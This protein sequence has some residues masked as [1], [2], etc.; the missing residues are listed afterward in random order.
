[1]IIILILQYKDQ[2]DLVIILK[3][4]IMNIPLFLNDTYLFEC[5]S[6]VAGIGHDEKGFYIVLDQTIF[7]PQGGGQPADQGVLKYGDAEIHILQV[8]QID[9]EIRHYVSASPELRIGT[10]V[11]AK[12]DQ[13]RRMLNARYHTAA[14][15]I[16]NIAEQICPAL[17]AIKGNSFPREAYVEFQG[18]EIPNASLLI[19]SLNKVIHDCL[20]TR[21]FKVNIKEF[22]EQ[23]YKLT[24][25][26][27]NN[28]TFRAMQI[29]DYPPVPCGGTHLSNCSEIGYIE[30]GKIK[31]KGLKFSS[32]EVKV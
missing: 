21:I 5:Q 32:H 15:L 10:C 3:D 28:K 31:P 14:H 26:I 12:I 23:F 30:I 19:E 18:S 17:K 11:T 22:E 16:G 27:P 8:K 9:S 7:Y 4:I 25:A 2:N 20:P 13:A 6:A 1:M 24:Y 29:K